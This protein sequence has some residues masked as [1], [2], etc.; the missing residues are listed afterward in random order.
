MVSFPLPLL[1]TEWDYFSLCPL[2][3]SGFMEVKAINVGVLKSVASLL[4][5]SFSNLAKLLLN[6]S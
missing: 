2:S 1:E 6:C 3:P 4:L 5:S